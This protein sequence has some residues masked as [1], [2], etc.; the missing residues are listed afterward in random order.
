[1]N[2]TT[3]NTARA[4]ASN[5]AA[6]AAATDTDKPAV[7]HAAKFLPG[8]GSLGDNLEYSLT[9]KGIL[10]LTIDLHDEQGVSSS[11]KSRIVAT[12]GGNQQVPGSN[13][14]VGINAYRKLPK[15]EWPEGVK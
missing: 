9:D 12:T 3:R 2:T 15:S 7:R 10:T 1:M 8:S 4:N 5:P 11:G 13:I 6:A 14:T